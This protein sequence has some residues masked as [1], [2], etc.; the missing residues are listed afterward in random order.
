LADV[1]GPDRALNIARLELE[2]QQQITNIKASEYRLLQLESEGNTIK[3]SIAAAKEATV[4]L[5]NQLKVAQEHL[6]NS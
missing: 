5:Q 6:L 2:V 3:Q 4:E 1:G